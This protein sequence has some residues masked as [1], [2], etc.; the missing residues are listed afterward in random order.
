LAH[1]REKETLSFKSRSFLNGV[2]DLLKNA[3]SELESLL[4]D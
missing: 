4:I 1:N 3:S 2:P